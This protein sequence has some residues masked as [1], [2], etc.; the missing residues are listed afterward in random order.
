LR[1]EKIV[2]P[3][4]RLAHDEGKVVFTDR[5]LPGETV[6]VEILKDK[7]TF[8]EGRTLRI[9]ERSPA[10]VEPRCGHYLACSPYQ[11]M[12]YGAQLAVKKA[13]VE[14]ILGR[15]LKFDP[16]PL[17]ITPS[18][19]IWG[20]RNRIRLRV[21]WKDGKA[22]AYY[23]EP[24]EETAF[25]PVDRCYL[26]SDR[27]NDLLAE[28]VDFLNGQEWEAVSGLEI[29]ESRSRGRLMAVFH[30]ESVSRIE[31]MAG[32][33]SD[34]HHR[35]PLSGIVG[36]VQDGN[37]IRE[38]T[39]GGVPRLEESVGGV[40]YRIGPRSFFQSNVGILEKV[41]EDMKEA[42]RG[43]AGAG[44][45][46]LYSGLGTFGFLLAG[47]AREVFGVEPD[48]ANLSFLKKN[49]RLNKAGN[50][51]VCEGTSEEWLPSLLERGIGIVILDPPRKGVD[52][53][54]LRELAGSEVPLVL[55]LSCNPAT[56]V[57]DLKILVPAYEIRELKIYDF[58][59]HT[60]H[61]ETLAVLG[62]G[63]G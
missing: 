35:F 12:D 40:G 31:E 3:G 43:Q 55:Y 53:G 32:K 5:G 61:I 15:E 18:P 44:V 30:L 4:R 23:H 38:E 17:M 39:L 56:L 6:E 29:R 46:D 14:E 11:D 9:V 7:K 21:L 48:P 54:M 47:E 34:L 8:A 1:I 51:T 16:G 19:E 57:R 20:Y 25:L 26:V 36:I 60:P 52:P 22:N 2:Y 50:F 10:R 33:L 58:F 45:A 62:R 63:R 37:R 28:L 59:P 27:V 13:Q 42:A 49:M 41:F 24:G